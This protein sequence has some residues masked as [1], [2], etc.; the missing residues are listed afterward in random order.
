MAGEGKNRGTAERLALYLLVVALVVSSINAFFVY[1]ATHAV[2][3]YPTILRTLMGDKG[4]YKKPSSSP[5]PATQAS[6]ASPEKAATSVVAENPRWTASISVQK[7][8]DSEYVVSVGMTDEKGSPV[9]P[10]TADIK[11]SNTA[12]PADTVQPKLMIGTD[13]RMSGQASFKTPGA[14]DVVLDVK[15]GEQ[16]YHLSRKIEIK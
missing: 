13:D 6:G 15:A 11:F 10:D 1:T 9:K 3:D 4:G 2:S 16:S 8:S 14:W 12:N 7:S 5:A